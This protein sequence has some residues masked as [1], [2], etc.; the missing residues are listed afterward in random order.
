M[1]APLANILDHTTDDEFNFCV[2]VLPAWGH[3]PAVLQHSEAFVPRNRPFLD[4]VRM[5]EHERCAS[6]RL[7]G[8]L[9]VVRESAP[10]NCL[11]TRPGHL[12]PPSDPPALA[13]PE[14]DTPGIV[15]D[16]AIVCVAEDKGAALTDGA[17][18]ASS[19]DVLAPITSIEAVEMVDW[20]F[21]RQPGDE[22]SIPSPTS[23]VMSE[24]T[25]TPA[26]ALPIP[27]PFHLDDS[28]RETLTKLAHRV[29]ARIAA[30]RS[31][32]TDELYMLANW[33]TTLRYLATEIPMLRP[34]PGIP[35]C[36]VSNVPP[37]DCIPLVSSAETEPED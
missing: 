1:Y 2:Q 17:A 29:H 10:Q 26:D 6:A 37:G 21:Q 30:A 24:V 3:M 20:I 22:D 7:E 27:E 36:P 28:E 15:A 5:L 9:A 31:D 13:A 16:E 14:V 8:I 33:Y 18:A 34:P 11:T 19:S 32:Y 25:E 35:H 12:G 23:V 4:I